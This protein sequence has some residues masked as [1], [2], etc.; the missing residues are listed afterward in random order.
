MPP[1]VVGF[2]GEPVMFNE[3]QTLRIS[4]EGMP[5]APESLYEAQ[6]KKRLGAVPGWLQSL[7]AVAQ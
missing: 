2:H 6:L 1:V 7:K 4:G 3:E 5:V